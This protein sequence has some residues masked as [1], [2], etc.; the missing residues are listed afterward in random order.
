MNIICR[1]TDCVHLF[2]NNVP[3]RFKV[4]LSQPVHLKGSWVIGLR[5]LTTT[6]WTDNAVSDDVYV[7][8][9]LC[10]VSF[11]G[12]KEEPLL[13]RVFLG[14]NPKANRIYLR[15]V[16]IPVRLGEVVQISI[17]I[18]DRAGND[19]SFLDGPITCELGMRRS[20]I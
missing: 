3:H 16:Y 8:C 19:A 18:K 6:S 9:N 15:P 10:D 7:Y 20:N 1:S 13:K 17:I 5:E 12:D 14:S 2:P 4:Q 11:V